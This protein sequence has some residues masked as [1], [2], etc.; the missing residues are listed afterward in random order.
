MGDAGVERRLRTHQLEPGEVVE[1]SWVAGVPWSQSD[2]FR[3]RLSKYGGNL[4]LT[5]KRVL[6]D[7]LK[8]VTP[9][10]GSPTG[11]GLEFLGGK[12]AFPL[13]EIASVERFSTKG[14]PRLKL[15]LDEGDE[16]ILGVLKGRTATIWTKD[17]SARDEAIAMITGAIEAARQ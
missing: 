3:G 2:S 9:K 17:T 10:R 5:N 7:P 16:V 4:V 11:F 14:P 13:E 8:V 1:R 6:F 15:T 12:R